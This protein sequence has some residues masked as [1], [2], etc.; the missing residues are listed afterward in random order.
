MNL[1]Q[2][3]A[4]IASQ[5]DELGALDWQ[6]AE[7]MDAENE[8]RIGLRHATEDRDEMETR[9]REI[10]DRFADAGF[11]SPTPQDKYRLVFGCN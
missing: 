8:L 11:I 4:K 9:L 7:L 3:L 2:A 1:T 10:A 5:E 6:I